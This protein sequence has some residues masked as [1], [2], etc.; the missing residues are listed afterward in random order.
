MISRGYQG[1]GSPFSRFLIT[2]GGSAPLKTL[3]LALLSKF[4]DLA[5][6]VFSIAMINYALLR[7]YGDI[8][9]C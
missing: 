7:G 6:K 3:A 8:S 5:S 1:G 9:N 2:L 4:I